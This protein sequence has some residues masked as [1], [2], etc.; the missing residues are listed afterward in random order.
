MDFRCERWPPRS[1]EREND[2]G[3]TSL[4]TTRYAVEKKRIGGETAG[5]QA[6]GLSTRFMGS[7]DLSGRQIGNLVTRRYVPFCPV[8]FFQF[9]A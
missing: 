5:A 3:H 7:T 1:A 8:L 9:I 2:L 4:F 6:S